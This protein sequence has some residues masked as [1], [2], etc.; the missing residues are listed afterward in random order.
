MSY[1]PTSEFELHR[2]DLDVVPSTAPVEKRGVRVGMAVAGGSLGAAVGLL[3]VIATGLPAQNPVCW[4]TVACGIAIG[5]VL[6]A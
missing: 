3:A 5:A 4:L 2:Q 1:I 6:G